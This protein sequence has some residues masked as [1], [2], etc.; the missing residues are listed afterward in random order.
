VTITLPAANPFTTSSSSLTVN[1]TVLNVTSS[2]QISVSV[3]GSATTAF[4]FNAASKKVSLSPSLIPGNNSISIS[5]SNAGGSDSKTQ[6]VILTSVSSAPKPVVTIS[7]PASNPFTSAMAS[8]NISATILN[9]TS[10]SQISV[11]LNGAT[12]SAFS[13]NAASHQ[14]TMSPAL[15][16]GANIL[17][18][19]ATNSSGSDA[20]SQTII[21]QPVAALPKPVVTI[22]SPS[23]SPYTSSVTPAAIIA[24]VLNVSSLGQIAVSVNGG[25]V[26]TPS[27]TFNSTSGNLNFNANLVAGANTITISATNVAGSDSK[28]QTIIYQPVAA[29]PAPVVTFIKPSG[30]GVTS[31]SGTY[32]V[33]AKVLNVTSPGQITVKVNGSI[34]SGFTFV[35]ATNKVAFNAILTIGSNAI[36]VSATNASGT[37]SKTT[38]I[39]HKLKP[40]SVLQPDTLNT[41]IGP[42]GGGGTAGGGTG[43]T[44]GPQITILTP[45]TSPFTTSDASLT[46]MAKIEGIAS[47]SDVVVKV[48]GVIQTAASYTVKTKMLNVP[49]NLNLGANTV[50]I[51]ASSSGVVKTG[52]VIIIRN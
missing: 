5:A 23:S 31:L 25:P 49:V 10:S 42:T 50:V 46:V 27:L 14:L 51:T 3:N 48:N 16:P 30:M 2:S 9:I 29:L 40:V 34:I 15:I 7:I 1:A 13:F 47:P 32:A 17:N 35:A 12:T 36:Q 11:T 41:P 21:Y 45:A 28:T 38:N 22:L 44:T 43:T 24:K 37:D 26:P 52:T 8:A 6:T 18:I 39:V 19:S 20:K 4:S 33:E